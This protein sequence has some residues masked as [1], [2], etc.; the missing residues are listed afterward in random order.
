M[1]NKY[2]D[3]L[4]TMADPDDV[5]GFDDAEDTADPDAGNENSENTSEDSEE[6]K[7]KE[8]NLEGSLELSV[9][10]GVKDMRRFLFS[11]NY[12]SISGW[13]GV[14]ISIFAIVML[15]IGRNRY[16]AIQII[17][18]AFVAAIFTI[19]QPIQI[20]MKAKRQIK[21]QPMYEKPIIYNLS[22]EGI[23]VRQDDNRAD[24]AWED[25]FKLTETKSGIYIYTSAVRAFIFPKDQIDDLDAFKAVLDRKVKLT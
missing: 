24:V 6:N 9:Q 21:L 7:V 1:K 5:A 25:V 12:R 3:E 17:G 10:P 4:K 2:I 16:N 13:F 15:I 22:E 14:L 23:T 20:M 11:H 19:V 8:F 18:L